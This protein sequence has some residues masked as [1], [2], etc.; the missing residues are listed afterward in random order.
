MKIWLDGYLR[1]ASEGGVSGATHALHYGTAVFEG[2]RSYT[3]EDRCYLFRLDDHIDRLFNSAKTLRLSVPY[4]G[5][6]IESAIQRVLD[7]NNLTNA[8]IRPLI[9]VGEGS[10]GLD[11]ASSHAR[12]S[13][14]VMIM[15]WEWK[16]YFNKETPAG[17]NVKIGPWKRS[18][19]TADLNKVKA[20]GFY[21]NSYLAYAD[22]KEAGYDE[23]ILVDENWNLAEASASNVFVVMGTT[24]ITPKTTAALPGITRSTIIDIARSSGFS[25]EIR[26]IP[27]EEVGQADHAF[28]TGTACEVVPIAKINGKSYGNRSGS[29]ITRALAALYQKA[30]RNQYLLATQNT[31]SVW[32]TPLRRSAQASVR[33]DR[34]THTE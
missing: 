4:S 1:E 9:F 20:S 23:A 33:R 11:I 6:E 3:G 15:A 30:V 10:M 27:I 12:N 26:D 5:A 24:L 32:C 21:V 13:I 28:L 31:T 29:D 14:H 22:A 16:S 8:Y 19:Q 18:F 2:I 34:I 7:V 25:V 17:L